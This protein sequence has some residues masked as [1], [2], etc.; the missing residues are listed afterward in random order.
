MSGLVYVSNITRQ[1]FLAQGEP[2]QQGSLIG[3]RLMDDGSLEPVANSIRDLGNRPSAVQFSPDGNFLVAASIN[4][5]AAALASGSE[6]EIVVY[7]V[8]ADGTLGAGPTGAATSTLR[9]NVENRN[10]PS[11]IGFQIVGDNYVVVTEARE[12][13]ADGA[14]PAFLSLIHI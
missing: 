6:D 3:F 11:A 13:Q 2:A 9:G 10:L 4:A 12:F 7:Q 8:N 14:P 5:G 1:E